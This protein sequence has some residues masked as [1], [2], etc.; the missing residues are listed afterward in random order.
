TLLVGM[1]VPA[2]YA[3]A[4]YPGY[5]PPYGP[6]RALP[7][8]PLDDEPLL[9]PAE[10]PGGFRRPPAAG[11]Y[12]EPPAPD[13]SGPADPRATPRPA[14]APARPGGRARGRSAPPHAMARGKAPPPPPG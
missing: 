1:A 14:P 3:A 11:P 6:P 12:P 2:G 13:P 10:V 9:P 5:P 4:Q 7:L 8:P